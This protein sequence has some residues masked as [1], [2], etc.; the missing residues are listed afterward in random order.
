M[1]T[2]NKNTNHNYHILHTLQTNKHD[3]YHHMM[4]SNNT[5]KT[6]YNANI[7]YH[8]VI[9]NTTPSKPI[10]IEKKATLKPKDNSAQN[11]DTLKV[12]FSSFKN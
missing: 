10:N 3:D 11:M 7:E 9:F 4:P 5:E 1:Y 2:E 6:N 8:S 12:Q